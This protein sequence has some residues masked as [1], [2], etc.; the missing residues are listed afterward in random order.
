[1]KTRC[2]LLAFILAAFIIAPQSASAEEAA[3]DPQKQSTRSRMIFGPPVN[4]NLAGPGSMAEGVLMTGINTSFADKV[5]PFGDTS[6]K[7]SDVFSQ[8]WLLKVRYG[9]TDYLEVWTTTPYIHNRRTNP[10]PNPQVIYGI[11]DT[12]LAL[13]FCPWHE[14]RGDSFTASASAGV[15]LPMAAWGDDHPPGLG[16]MGFRGQAAVGKFVTK[17]IKIETEGV[18]N[19]RFARGNQNVRL[20]DQFQ[21]NSQIRY[22]FDYFDIGV[23]SSMV[24]QRTSDRKISGL[25]TRDLRNGYTEWFVGPSVNV[26]IE[27]LGMWAG[28]GAFFPVMRYTD[29]PTKVENV[30]VEFKIAKL[31]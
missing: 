8:T 22:L 17:D 4:V 10:E 14:R 26:A 28:I 16:V 9:I 20:G 31:W 24:W 30:R 1:M 23:E 13:T 19:T 29:S 25:G 7:R 15:W 5:T 2:I 3:K 12:V 18:W 27:P 6:R 21:W 11:G